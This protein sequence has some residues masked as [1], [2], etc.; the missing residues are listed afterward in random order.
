M[1][2]DSPGIR[3]RCLHATCGH[4]I[5]LLVATKETVREVGHNVLWVE[6]RTNSRY[7]DLIIN[8]TEM[9]QI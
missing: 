8:P 3:T 7:K 5:A 9:W 2:A 6:R 1:I 4:S